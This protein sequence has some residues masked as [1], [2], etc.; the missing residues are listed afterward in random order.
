MG[1]IELDCNLLNSN[2]E[3]CSTPIVTVKANNII[4]GH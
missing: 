1:G 4:N 3:F 2:L